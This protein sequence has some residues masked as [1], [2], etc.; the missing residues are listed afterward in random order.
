MGGRYKTR[1]FYGS[2]AMKRFLVSLVLL[3]TSSSLCF[4]EI[5]IKQKDRILNDR[6]GVCAWASLEMLARYH[7]IEK[8]YGITEWYKDNGDGNGANIKMIEDYLNSINVKYKTYVGYS[9]GDAKWKDWSA[10]DHAK[11]DR[12]L[13]IGVRDYPVPGAYHAILVTH[14]DGIHLKFVDSNDSYGVWEVRTG[15]D[16][17]DEHWSG[18]AIALIPD[19]DFP[20]QTWFLLAVEEV[21]TLTE[22]SWINLIMQGGALVILFY[23][24]YWAS[25]QLPRAFEKMLDRQDKLVEVFREELKEERALCEQRHQSI[26][27]ELKEIK[28]DLILHR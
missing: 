24:A 22:P 25:Q 10:L 7:G 3:L 4:A 18:Y 6:N 17:L 23:L 27:L 20:M 16:W 11:I 1:Q 9:S 2:V 28:N 13:V 8:I 19:E 12:G 26:L 14:W 5:H 15:R 21:K